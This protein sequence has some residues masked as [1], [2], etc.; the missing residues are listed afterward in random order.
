MSIK[1]ITL[2]YFKGIKGPVRIELKPITLLFG[3]NSAGKSTVVQALHYAR[4][5]F[6]RGNV[7]PDQTI[8]GGAM[9]LGGFKQLVFNNDPDLPIRLCFELSTER[10]EFPDFSFYEKDFWD[11]GYGGCSPDEGDVLRE[12]GSFKGSHGDVDSM[13]IEIEVRWSEHLRSPVI[14][15]YRLDVNDMIFGVVEA[16]RDGRQVYLS[17]V[18]KDHPF[19]D[20]SYSLDTEI[21]D[22]YEPS[23]VVFPWE[24]DPQEPKIHESE[25]FDQEAQVEALEYHPEQDGEVDDPWKIST[26]HPKYIEYA[27]GGMYGPFK[28][29]QVQRLVDEQRRLNPV[30]SPVN[31][32]IVGQDSA[33]P[34]LNRLVNLAGSE[35]NLV[36][37]PDAVSHLFSAS[38]VIL[39][40]KLK[41]LGYIGPIREV[42]P[43]SFTP[44][45]TPEA[46]RWANGLAAWDALYMDKDKIV[47]RANQW[48][49]S[50]KRLASG[51]RLLLKR[52][53]ELD[54]D[55]R[56]MAAM[57]NEQSLDDLQVEIEN[58]LKLPV[59]RR[60][61]L[62]EEAKQLEVLPQDV[63]VGISQVI[64]VVVAA[65]AAQKGIV[66]VEQPEL[67]IHPA[68]QVALGDL[69]I[70]ESSSK[71]VCFLLETHS[72]HLML[73]FMRRIR[74]TSDGEL[75]PGALPL[76][77]E[78]LSVYY[79]EPTERGTVFSHIRVDKDGDFIDRWPH[80]FFE[81][82]AKELF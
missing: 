69:F 55:G 16:S 28:Q 68:F 44:R 72:E 46:S 35:G 60:L 10:K 14:T 6:E 24:D 80:G 62:L 8:T 4:E 37:E 56:L 54:A 77:P 41:S 57:E 70:E 65:L 78:G 22:D 48:L 82:R 19:L 7:D 23:D 18:W 49:A 27:L 31:V 13:K 43:R 15:Q 63:G 73:R 20:Q 21:W 50:D 29:D 81:E 1:S 45:K 79:V 59:K 26:S 61:V 5:I 33:L 76:T 32:T 2:E 64:P 53:R 47:Q 39:T 51:Y 42:P 52:Y 9:D 36:P 17:K 75:E 25:E 30:Y 11:G 34:P 12:Q 67:H 3:P 66:A 58:F 74:E 40:N 38:R 71:D